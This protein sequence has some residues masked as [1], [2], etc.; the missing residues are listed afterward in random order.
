[1][2]V[3][4]TASVAELAQGLMRRC[5]TIAGL[6]CYDIQSPKPEPPAVCVLGP[7]RW[8]YDDTMDGVWR[9]VFELTLYY[10]A[11]N[12]VDAQ[13]ELFAYVAPSGPKSIPAAV[14]GDP[15]LGGVANDTRVV[16]GSR[17]ASVVETAGGSLLSLA[18]EV[19]VWAM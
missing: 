8:T 9:P 15:S 4:V 12:L 17:P 5:Q 11:A 2:A 7:V 3:A 1:M 18:L 16:G 13:R 14:Y 10:S 6:R 19:E